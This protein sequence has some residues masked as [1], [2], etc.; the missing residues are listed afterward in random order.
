MV[1]G[2]SDAVQR[3]MPAE[4]GGSVVGENVLSSEVPRK[5]LST[6]SK[7]SYQDM[8]TVSTTVSTLQAQCKAAVWVSRSHCSRRPS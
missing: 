4:R 7:R 3:P 1:T 5:S 8:D 6:G 2:T